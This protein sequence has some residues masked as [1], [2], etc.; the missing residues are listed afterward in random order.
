MMYP[1]K[2]VCVCL[3]EAPVFTLAEHSAVAN[4]ELVHA[5]DAIEPNKAELG[6]LTDL[7]GITNTP[8]QLF[9]MLMIR[10][11]N[12]TER[13]ALRL[14]AYLFLLSSV[15]ASNVFGYDRPRFW[16]PSPC[17]HPA[18]ML[19]CMG[20]MLRTVSKVCVC[21]ACVW[22]V[23]VCVYCRGKGNHDSPAISTS[24]ALNPSSGFQNADT[25]FVSRYRHGFSLVTDFGFHGKYI[26]VYDA[27]GRRCSCRAISNHNCVLFYVL[28]NLSLLTFNLANCEGKP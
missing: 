9:R 15:D 14:P 3:Q 13:Q 8:K 21:V 25:L 12:R 6:F 1:S 19:S 16:V 5:D 4:G 27:L 7:P 20:C 10:K 26:L 22:Y 11:S 23:C 18:H 24:P 2:E 17:L 28:L